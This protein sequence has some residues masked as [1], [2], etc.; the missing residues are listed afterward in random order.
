[1]RL[2]R[3]A[4][5]ITLALCV[6][7]LLRATPPAVLA[8]SGAQRLVAIGDIH[9]AEEN[10]VAILQ[11]SGL[12]DQQ[13]K[14]IGGRA[15]LVQTGDFTDRGAAVRHV[16]DLLMRLEDEA[17]RAGGRV[18][19]LLGNHEAMNILRDLRDVS[20]DAFQAFADRDS[21]S[22]R[23]KAFIAHATI[24]RRSGEELNRNDWLRAH[25]PGY[26]EYIDAMGPSGRYGRWLR[27]RKVVTKIDDSLFM[28]AGISPESNAGIDDVN[29][30]VEREIRM[31]DEAVSTLQQSGLIAPS[32]TLQEIA[33]ALSAEITRIATMLKEK[34][35]LGPE[36]TQEYVGRLQRVLTIDKWSLLAADGPLWFRGYATLGDEAQPQIEA[37]LKRLGG[38]RFVVGHTP[39]LPGRITPRYGNRI[40]LIDTGMLTSYFKNGRPSALEIAGGKITAIYADDRAV[41]V[42]E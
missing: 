8:Q 25:P 10:F 9:G 6:A 2:W 16:I 22:R 41:L 40:F 34:Q 36:V 26:L 1:M 4:L 23:S 42:G 21:E 29:R 3:R 35:E 12:I 11:A 19:V 18:E 32:F 5:S 13:R 28:H 17:K 20:P 31:F 27:S 33:A 14:W 24:A 30:I 39:Q 15:R 7:A 37:L 38:A